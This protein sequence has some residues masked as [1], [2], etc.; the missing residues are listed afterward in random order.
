MVDVLM[1]LPRLKLGPEISS[2]C[3]V[4]KHHYLKL[5]Q[6]WVTHNLHVTVTKLTQTS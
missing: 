2:H 3:H 5:L 6:F 1:L 4:S